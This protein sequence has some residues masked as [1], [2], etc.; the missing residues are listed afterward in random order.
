VAQRFL[1]AI[2]GEVI[3]SDADPDF[4]VA[5]GYEVLAGGS[6]S[7]SEWF[8]AQDPADQ[9]RKRLDRLH[10]KKVWDFHWDKSSS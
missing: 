9:E 7:N 6:V 8:A 4:M 1:D 5:S 10:G 3:T 2:T